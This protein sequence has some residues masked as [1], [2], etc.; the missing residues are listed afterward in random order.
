MAKVDGRAEQ[1]IDQYE[2]VLGRFTD[3]YSKKI[4]IGNITTKDIREYLA[5]LM[6]EGLRNTTVAIHYRVLNRFFNWLVEEYY[7]THSPI[8]PINE[9]KIPKTFPKVLNEE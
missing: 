7:L 5:F 9:P 2:Y 1:T 4:E 8:E 3:Y 6:D